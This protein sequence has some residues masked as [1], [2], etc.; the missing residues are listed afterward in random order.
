MVP[1]TLIGRR[2]V[3]ALAVLLASVTS[4]L[5][6][7]GRQKPYVTQAPAYRQ[8]GPAEA[9]VT[10]VEFSDFECPACRYAVEPLKRLEAIYGKDLRLVYKHFPLRFHAHARPAA[11]A[12]EC[13]GRQGKFWD[14]FELLY[15]KQE[16]WAKAGGVGFEGYAKGMG[17]DMGAF[18]A[19]LKDP[20]V[21]A[22]IESDKKEAED[23]WVVSTPT[24]FINGKRFSGPR[25]LSERGVRWID[26]I[27][28]QK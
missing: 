20:A 24:F 25:Q 7:R 21:A 1:A 17:L 11:V 19:C 23:R 13:A 15:A 22:L 8:K 12:A 28:G 10:V 26:K 3:C 4:V 18:S 16:D 6:V 27:L 9:Q 2:L 5:A 14:F